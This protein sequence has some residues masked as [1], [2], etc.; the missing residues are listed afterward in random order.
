MGSKKARHQFLLEQLKE[1]GELN[2]AIMSSTLGISLVTIRKDLKELEQEGKLVRIHGGARLSFSKSRNPVDSSFVDTKNIVAKKAA[3]L[4]KDGE[5]IFL[6]SGT[7]CI[8]IAK[9]IKQSHKNLTIVSNNLNI[10]TE[11]AG[12]PTFS[13]LGTG[14]QINYLETFSV[15]HGDFVINFL[16]RVLVQKAFLTADGVSL[17]NGYTTH[18]RN[19]FHLYESIRKISEEMIF[20]VEGQK[21]N[22][23]SILRLA[24]MESINTIVSD[25]SIPVEFKEYYQKSGKNLYIGSN[26]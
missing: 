5:I 8:E 17:K 13:V 26:E 24:E 6:G 1:T 11:L 19:E 2:A 12:T 16:D 22:R 10:L 25:T 15:F 7:T 4:I 18:N 23:N 21:F 9:Q 20:V 3:S 14:G